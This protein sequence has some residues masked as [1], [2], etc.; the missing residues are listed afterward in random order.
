MSLLNA[1][2]PDGTKPNL[3]KISPIPARALEPLIGIEFSLPCLDPWIGAHGAPAHAYLD[4]ARNAWDRHPEWMDLLNPESP[5]HQLKMAQYDLYRHHWRQGL[6]HA[7]RILDIG[8]GVGRFTVPLVE[9][10]RTLIGVDGDLKSLQ[11]CAWGCAGYSGNLDLYWTTG[12]RLPNI[13]PVEAVIAVE[14]LC[15]MPNAE[16]VMNELSHLLLSGGQMM[17]SLEAKWGWALAEDAPQ[18]GMPFALTGDIVDL[19]DDRWVRTFS[20]EEVIGLLEGA[21][22]VVDMVIP[23]NYVI[24]GPLERVAPESVNFSELLAAEEAAAAHPVY[25]PLNRTWTA[26]AHKP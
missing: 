16:K 20:K 17:L 8:C 11:R 22:L 12:N 5:A 24:D 10:G 18:A 9:E 7:E 13:E 1:T 4:A 14:S 15:Y 21:G 23:S 2:L 26:L 25:G 19:P 3:G 6:V